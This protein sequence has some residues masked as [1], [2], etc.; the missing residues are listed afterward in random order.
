MTIDEYIEHLEDK[1]LYD[2]SGTAKSVYE[3]IKAYREL[4]EKEYQY[5]VDELKLCNNIT[6]LGYSIDDIK[7]WLS[8]DSAKQQSE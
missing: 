4:K 7:G 5:E 2:S 8:E 1:F 6:R 3:L